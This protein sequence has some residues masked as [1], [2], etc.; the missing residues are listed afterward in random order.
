M[1]SCSYISYLQDKDLWFP[2]KAL[3]LVSFEHGCDV[4]DFDLAVV[5]INVVVLT[6]AQE[7]EQEAVCVRVIVGSSWWDRQ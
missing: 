1:L 6:V 2:Y 3:A 4:L 5:G 7:D